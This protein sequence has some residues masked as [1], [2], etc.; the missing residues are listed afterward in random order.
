MD[1]GNELHPEQPLAAAPATATRR[2]GKESMM[3]KN[4]CR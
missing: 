2:T 3:G 1:G 4:Q